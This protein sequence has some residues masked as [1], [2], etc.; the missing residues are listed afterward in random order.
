[1]ADLV[2]ETMLDWDRSPA[3]P[4]RW[5]R[6]RAAADGAARGAV[7][8]LRD[9]PTRALRQAAEAVNTVRPVTR[10]APARRSG[11]VFLTWRRR[12]SRSGCGCGW[13]RRPAALEPGT[14]GDWA[15][16]TGECVC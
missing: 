4:G 1:V 2:K 12:R 7:R 6:A 8:A 11:E 10:S 16:A 5:P 14:E 3:A 13:T 15:H 9:R